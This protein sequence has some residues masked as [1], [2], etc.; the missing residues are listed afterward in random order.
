MHGSLARSS[1]LRGQAPVLGPGR[2]C[3][4]QTG[5]PPSQGSPSPGF[6]SALRA[7]CH[8]VRVS[9]GQRG[10]PAASLHHPPEPQ[11]TVRSRHF[12]GAHGTHLGGGPVSG[13]ALIPGLA[14]MPSARPPSWETYRSGRGQR[15]RLGPCRHRRQRSLRG[16]GASGNN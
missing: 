3:L 8:G 5:E 14:E 13:W 4:S 9:E 15:S 16:L 12:S 10:T 2:A 7:R 11:V 6:P 1:F